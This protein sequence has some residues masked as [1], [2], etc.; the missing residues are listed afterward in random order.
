[1]AADT[2][3][4]LMGTEQQPSRAAVA[5]TA[6]R[7]GVGGADPRPLRSHT[8]R[9]ADVVVAGCLLVL[10]ALPIA[11]IAAAIRVSMGPPILFR[12]ARPGLNGEP[13]T[14]I[15]F[16]TMRDGPGDDAERITRLGR[17]LRSTSLDE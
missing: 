9:G 3:N 7:G 13:F 15:K 1:P 4:G 6:L 12:Q 14:L 11:M 10:A 2:L 16:R 5:E 17:F 8:K